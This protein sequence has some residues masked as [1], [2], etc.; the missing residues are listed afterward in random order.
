[1]IRIG[2]NRVKVYGL[3]IFTVS[4][5]EPGCWCVQGLH[6]AKKKEQDSEDHMLKL[7][8]REE[9]RL[10]QEIDKIQKELNDLKEKENAAEV[11]FPHC[12]TSQ[13]LIN[14]NLQP[15]IGSVLN[16]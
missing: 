7:A 9:G 3:L 15:L 6:L 12:F 1:M 4:A 16:Y 2:Q 8:E 13:S 10:K 11:C 14:E 5:I